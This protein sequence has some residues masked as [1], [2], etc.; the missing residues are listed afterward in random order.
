[1]ESK[2]PDF[3]Y[4]IRLCTALEISSTIDPPQNPLDYR[5][6]LV[7]GPPSQRVWPSVESSG[8]IFWEGP[9]FDFFRRT[10]KIGTFWLL[11][12]VKIRGSSSLGF[13]LLIP[14]S[15]FLRLDPSLTQTHV[16]RILYVRI[17]TSFLWV[18]FS[19]TANV[20]QV[21]IWFVRSGISTKPNTLL[22]AIR[23]IA[24]L[25]EKGFCLML[26]I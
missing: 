18:F 1:M 14:G 25:H 23:G 15:S 4:Q 7:M 2:G 8:S 26:Y 13:T 3:F 5:H 19:N 17:K 24:I 9:S 16:S 21:K 10:H 6:R 22:R 12:W 11:N 20:Y